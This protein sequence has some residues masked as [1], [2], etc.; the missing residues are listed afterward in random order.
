MSVYVVDSNFFI[1]AHRA[2]YPFDVAVSFWSKVELL[3][4][5][6]LIISIDKVQNEIFSH[7][8][9][10]REW[11]EGHLIDTFFRDTSGLME[12][13]AEV[14]RWAISRNSHFTSNAISEFLDADVA[15]A[16]LVAFAMANRG[17]RIIVTQEISQP[18]GKSK[19][20]IPQ[21]CEVFG[22]RYMNLISMFRDL[23]ESF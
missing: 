13:Y 14:V 3:A 20:K 10:L 8:D 11:C 12:E 6:G 4:N 19:I 18:N 21:P 1:Q 22:I 17:E 16:F 23:H 7:N 9:A 15:D 2:T 5:R